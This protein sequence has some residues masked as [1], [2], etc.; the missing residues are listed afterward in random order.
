MALLRGLLALFLL[1]GNLVIN[2]IGISVE[3]DGGIIRST[4]NMIFWSVL[5]FLIALPYMLS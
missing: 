5:A 3:D 4:I 1:P 2:A